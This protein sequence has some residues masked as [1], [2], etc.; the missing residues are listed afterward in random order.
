MV[1]IDFKV[2]ESF[3]GIYPDPVPAKKIVPEWYKKMSTYIDGRNVPRVFTKDASGTHT[4]LTMKACIPIRDVITSGYIIPL[5]VDVI[6][7]QGFDKDGNSL[8]V[9]IGAQQ[10]KYP[11]PHLSTHS[12]N[13]FKN[14][15]ISKKTKGG[16]AFKMLSPW[17]IYTPLGYSCYF[18]SPYFH[19]ND[20]KIIPGIVDT[21]KYH[22]INFPFTLSDET[23][24]PKVVKKGTPYVQVLPFKR[25]EYECRISTIS[26]KDKDRMHNTMLGWAGHLYRDVFHTKK[27]YN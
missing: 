4:N 20:L 16:N 9:G 26:Q 11:E 1:K 2:L 24:T 17:R 27:K 5:H 22:E 23:V 15:V 10:D 19:E 13:Q 18:F 12:I 3:E 6:V 8:G 7:D 25:D 14:S 21:D